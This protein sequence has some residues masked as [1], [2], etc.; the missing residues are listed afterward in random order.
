M[1][2]MHFDITLITKVYHPEVCGGEREEVTASV[3]TL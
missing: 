2:S 3:A 1:I